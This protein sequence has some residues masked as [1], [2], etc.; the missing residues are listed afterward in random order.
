MD[1][2]E[3]FILIVGISGM[4]LSGTAIYGVFIEKTEV[5]KTTILDSTTGEYVDRYYEHEYIPDDQFAPMSIVIIVGI[6]L[7]TIGMYG[8]IKYG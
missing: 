4:L 5:A 7:I 2:A 8:V 1:N 6:I 3:V